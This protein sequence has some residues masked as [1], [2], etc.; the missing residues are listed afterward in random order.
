M[1]TYTYSS[2]TS[3]KKH[4]SRD[5][6]TSAARCRWSLVP[7]LPSFPFPVSTGTVP[8]QRVKFHRPAPVRLF[9]D[10]SGCFR[11]SHSNY[12]LFRFLRME[13]RPFGPWKKKTRTPALFASFLFHRRA[14][15]KPTK[16]PLHSQGSEAVPYSTT[17]LREKGM[18]RGTS[19]ESTTASRG[20][21][22]IG[23]GTGGWNTVCLRDIVHQVA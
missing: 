12:F 19:T 20:Q 1:P 18:G 17:P 6:K 9:V 3:S 15:A 14:S 7:S 13:S 8:H 22:A 10:I 4:S 2:E 23:Y 21:D 5:A 11:L 16:I